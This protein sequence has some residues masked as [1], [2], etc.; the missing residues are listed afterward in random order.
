MAKR[1]DRF[2]RDLTTGNQNPLILFKRFLDDLFLIFRGSTKELL[3]LFQKINQ[4][5]PAIKLTMEHTSLE[6]EPLNEK[7]DC[8]LKKSIQFL[9]TSCEIKNGKIEI[10][11]YRKNTDRNQY[12]LPSSCHPKQTTTNIPFSLCLRILRICTNPEIRQDL[13]QR[14]LSRNYPERIIDSAIDRANKILRHIALRKTK[15]KTKTKSKRPV[16]A[17]RYDPRLPAIENIQAKH[18]RSMKNQ[19]GYLAEVFQ[20]PP[21]TGYKRQKNLRD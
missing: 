10:D 16:F 12:L 13:K 18:W 9:D 19:D 11:L 4:I 5:H 20:E 15:T 2:I 1:I 8:T 6:N 21:L 7:R 14:L 3:N 17:L